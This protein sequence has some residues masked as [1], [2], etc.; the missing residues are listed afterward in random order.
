MFSALLDEKVDAVVA[1][2]FNRAQV[3]LLVH[4]DSPLRKKI[5]CALLVLREN[6][7]YQNIFQ[8]WFGTDSPQ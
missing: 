7:T 1:P 5:D 4:L 8:K 6:G 3:A 2:E